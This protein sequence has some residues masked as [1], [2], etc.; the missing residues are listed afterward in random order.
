MAVAI[1][2]TP[3]DIEN[4]NLVLHRPAEVVKSIN[5]ALHPPAVLADKEVPLLEGAEARIELES[6]GLG[7]AEKLALE[8]EPDLT[9]CATV[10]PA[11]DIQEVEGEGTED[12]RQDDAVDMLPCQGLSRDWDVEEDVVVQ[13]VASESEKDQV[14]P[15]PIGGRR[16]V[17]DDRDQG[18]NVLDTSSLEVELGDHQI[19]L[20]RPGGG[21]GW[22]VSVGVVEGGL[23]VG[24]GEEV[25]FRLG[26][27][28]SESVGLGAL[29]VPS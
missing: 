15:S 8:R 18:L 24:E 2:E 17:E 21:R 29:T 11:N 19:A 12:P 25:V 10:G 14:P 1:V 23:P 5:H 22:S 28:A 27:T 20:S 7:V 9:C 3:Q 16:G 6:A 26:N 4:H 13:G